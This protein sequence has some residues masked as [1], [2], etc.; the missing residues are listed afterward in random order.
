M[1]TIETLVT[2]TVNDDHVHN[3][4]DVDCTASITAAAA[5]ARRDR[6]GGNGVSRSVT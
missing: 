5:A 6:D 4:D 2:L 1:A 3:V